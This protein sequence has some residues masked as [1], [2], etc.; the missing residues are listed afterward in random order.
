MEGLVVEDVGW[1]QT[2][3]IGRRLRLRN[4]TSSSSSTTTAQQQKK[5]STKAPALPL[6]LAPSQ[7]YNQYCPMS[8]SIQ[9]LRQESRSALSLH[10]SPLV[11]LSIPVGR[12]H[13]QSPISHHAFPPLLF[14]SFPQVKSLADQTPFLETSTRPTLH[15]S[16]H[17]PPLLAL[18]SL[19][20]SHSHSLHP[21]PNARQRHHHRPPPTHSDAHQACLRP[22]SP[23]RH[24][25]RHRYQRQHQQTEKTIP[26]RNSALCLETH[27]RSRCH[28]PEIK[29]HTDIRSFVQRAGRLSRSCAL[30]GEREGEG[31]SG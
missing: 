27:G 28:V 5:Q 22:H 20:S 26:P 1:G 11:L 4:K 3:P 19:S 21:T 31:T 7:L 12:N 13:S 15:P 9:G 8:E 14:L 17:L 29:V 6:A 10:P 18:S 24:Q 16:P 23:P 30:E 2:A 25:H